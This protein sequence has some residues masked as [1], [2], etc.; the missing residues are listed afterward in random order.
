MKKLLG[1]ALS[2][3]ILA[4]TPAAGNAA[5]MIEVSCASGKF[6]FS[7]NPAGGQTKI[8]KRTYEVSFPVREYMIARRID[9]KNRYMVMDLYSGT[10]TNNGKP[11]RG[12]ICEFSNLYLRKV[13]N[14][15]PWIVQLQELQEKVNYL[16]SLQKK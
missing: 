1:L 3:T 10:V 4:L 2:I 6:K 8:G 9:K 12:L 15:K 13:I 11:N 14:D 7:V 5:D 16:E